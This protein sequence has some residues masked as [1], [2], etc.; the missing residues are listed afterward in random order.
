MSQKK[1]KE[2]TNA[3]GAWVLAVAFCSELVALI[4]S[5]ADPPPNG[6]CCSC[7]PCGGSVWMLSVFWLRPRPGEVWVVNSYMLL[8]LLES[9]VCWGQAVESSAVEVSG[10]HMA[11][12]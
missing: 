7:C 2:L 1:N 10:R 3:M 11:V 5:S 8:K 9:V 4:T 12:G 6:A